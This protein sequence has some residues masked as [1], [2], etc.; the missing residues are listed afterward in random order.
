M[1]GTMADREVNE[2]LMCT[3]QHADVVD[4]DEIAAADSGHGPGDPSAASVAGQREPGLL[5]LKHPTVALACQS[6]A[7]GQKP[8]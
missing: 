6:A 4:H 3:G 2:G 8:I 7:Q 5:V 1:I